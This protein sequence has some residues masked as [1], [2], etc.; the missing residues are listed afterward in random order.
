MVDDSRAQR[1]TLCTLLRRSGYRVD[2]ADSGA[3]ALEICH[4]TPPDLVISDWVM[5]GMNGLELCRAFRAM[6]RESYGYFILL[7]SKSERSEIALGLESGADDFLTKPV[8]GAEL[9][10]RLKAGQ[11]IVDMQREVT[12]KNHMLGDALAEVRRLYDL[13]DSDLQEARKLQD[14]LIRDRDRD[15]GAARMSLLLRSSGHVGGD[16]VGHFCAGSRQL[17]VYSIDVSGHGIT[18]AMLAARLAGHLSAADPDYNIALERRGSGYHALPTDQVVARLNEMMHHIVGSDHYFTIALAVIDLASGR[19]RLT[20]AGHPHPLV[21][22]ADGG[23]VTI[24]S[25]GLPVGL[26]EDVSWSETCIRLF[27]GD[28]LVLC[29]DGITECTN[30][31]D[32]MLEEAGLARILARH[33]DRA[34]ID[35]LETMM[36]DLEQYHGG[37]S[38][39]DDISAVMVE[40]TGP[41]G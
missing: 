34:G 18:S 8:N 37:D 40:Y 1:L 10:A 6:D 39:P 14:A 26:L 13:I 29:S 3:R 2:E 27:P 30:D 22:R 11:R 5:P 28:R 19:V 7:T 24:G 33:A 35:L 32:A 21:Q 20:Q 17:G 36:V 12:R 31:D 23:F 4:Q 41:T 38:Y 25:G 9:R 16:L 15:F